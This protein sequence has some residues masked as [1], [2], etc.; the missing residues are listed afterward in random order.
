MTARP[1]TLLLVVSLAFA[2]GAWAVLPDA[3]RFGAAIE[4]GDLSAARRWLDEGLDPDFVADRIGTGLMIAAWEGNL[5]ML[6]L[7]HGRGADVNR[8]NRA[9]EQALQLA[10]L[11]GHLQVVVWL[12]ERGAQVDRPG[13]HWSALHYAVFGGHAEIARLLLARGARAD[14]R[15]P[16]DSTAL[17]LAAREGHPGLAQMLVEAG[18]DTR[19]ANDWGDT[20]LGY[21][22]RYGHTRIAKMVAPPAEYAEAVRLPRAAFAPPTRSLPPPPQLAE[23]LQQLREAQAEGRPTDALRQALFDAVAQFRRDSRPLAPPRGAPRAL[24]VTARRQGGGERMELVYEPRPAATA[25]V[26]PRTEAAG[27]RPTP[28]ASAP[29]QTE[30]A[31][32]LA[33]LREAQ[34]QG[35]PTEGLR[36]EL[37]D[38][39]QRY[40]GAPASP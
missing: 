23:R 29:Q 2:G 5:A 30:V 6:E 14:A 19:A 10:A 17:M 39:V 21:A 34:A 13:K 28:T 25:P 3:V 9:G 38:A 26:L 24:V 36:R 1:R 11:R 8:V 4:V 27:A 16:N 33:R 32:I 37:R 35:R 7:F 12:L 18:A 15:T 31:G 22:M 20:A 40:K